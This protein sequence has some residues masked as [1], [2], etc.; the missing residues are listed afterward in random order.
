M[1][2]QYLLSPLL[3]KDARHY[4]TLPPNMN[5]TIDV[6]GHAMPGIQGVQQITTDAMGFRVQPPIDY[7]HKYGFRIFAIGASTTEEINLDDRSAW[8]YL[9]QEKLAAEIGRPVEVANTG[10]SGTRALHHRTMLRRILGY[11][12]DCALFLVGVND[13]NKHIREH[14]G[15]DYYRLTDA[16]FKWTLLGRGLQAAQLYVDHILTGG[17]QP[18]LD[19]GVQVE[20]GSYYSSQ[21]DSLARSDQRT[22]AV[23]D[24]APDYRAQIEEIGATCRAAGVPCIFL[25]QPHGYYEVIDSGYRRH[26][27]M[28]PPNEDYTLDLASMG[29]MADLYNQYLIRFAGEQGH[30]LI[31][32]AA[33]MPPGLAFFYDDVHFNTEGARRVANVLTDELTATA[34]RFADQKRGQRRE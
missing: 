3:L 34:C 23:D 1:I 9:L 7:G 33:A 11:E 28:T 17:G 4:V 25:T 21:N 16:R 13:W 18:D 10:L 5:Q 20:V 19:G 32:L 31:D 29:R 27:W 14:F 24:V 12:P 2:A 6:V 30:G 26:F 15:S 22:L 8:T